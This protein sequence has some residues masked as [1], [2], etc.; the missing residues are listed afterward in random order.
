MRKRK[1]KPERKIRTYW[2]DEKETRFTEGENESGSGGWQSGAHVSTGA[3]GPVG[4]QPRVLWLASLSRLVWNGR[5]LPW[6]PLVLLVSYFCLEVI[7]FPRS[8][9]E[10]SRI[11]SYSILGRGPMHLLYAE[12]QM[13]SLYELPHLTARTLSSFLFFSLNDNCWDICQPSM[14]IEGDL[15]PVTSLSSNIQ[16]GLYSECSFG[17]ELG[18]SKILLGVIDWKNVTQGKRW[19]LRSLLRSP[20]Q[21]NRVKSRNYER[22]SMMDFVICPLG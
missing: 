13:L 15:K 4:E 5:V 1:K 6:H 16:S 9:L 18:R 10:S 19:V 8:L 11:F 17:D 22:Q 7:I 12:M 14:Q 21:L 20:V 3:V 2:E